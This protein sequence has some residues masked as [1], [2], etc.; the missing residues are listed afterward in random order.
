MKKYII[1]FFNILITIF[2]GSLSF[3]Y[4]F[5]DSTGEKQHKCAQAWG[6][7]C[8]K[9]SGVNVLVKGLSN[10]NGNGPFIFTSNH[11]SYLD[12]W[13]ALATLPYSFR[14]LAKESLFK[15]PFIGWHLTR[16]GHIPIARE[17]SKSGVKS[18]LNT[19]KKIKNGTN[20]LI[21]PEGRRS[22]EGIMGEF[23]KGAF[24]LAAK[25]GVTLV[26]II[27]KNTAS[28]FP[29]GSLFV[30]PGKVEI[31]I[32]PQVDTGKFG[33]KKT[34]ELMEHVKKIMGDEFYLNNGV[35]KI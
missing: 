17:D 14:F 3:I 18:L 22:K 35:I 10:I 26:P 7:T 20:V 30:Y 16:S 34:D 9:N 19:V 31:N 27:M 6:K 12:I 33:S 23:K 15:W 4:S 1:L 13:I 28:L 8:L 24:L 29:E 11:Q 2:Y 5:F 25:T 21:F 32:L